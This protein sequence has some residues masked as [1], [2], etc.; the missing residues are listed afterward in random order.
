M[1]RL[2]RIVATGALLAAPLAATAQENG[3][4]V[5]VVTGEG[6]ATAAP[7][8]ALLSLGVVAEGE[9]AADA[10]AGVSE[11]L[12]PV[13]AALRD[14]GI[15]EAD[16]QTTGISVVPVY[17]APGPD[18]Q[19]A[20]RIASYEASSDLSA[21]L[22][23]LDTVGALLDAAI[24]AGANRVG[25]FRLDITDDAALA[26]AALQ[27]A[28][29]DA[30][31]KA[32]A[33]ADAAGQSLGAILEIREAGPDGGPGPMMEMRASAMPIAAGVI[34]RRATVTIRFAIGS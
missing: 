18:E 6:R 15:A 14:G 25:G 17:S 33:V 16:L 2:L 32:E 30:R 4:A 28:V 8:M 31:R 27:G 26:D 5:I 13:L 29:G 34:E 9:T 24:A 1:R 23:D 3:G 22:R 12:S 7:D 11:N 20:P 19:T 10:V 21:V